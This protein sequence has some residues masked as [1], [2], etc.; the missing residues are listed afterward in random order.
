MTNKEIHNKLMDISIAVASSNDLEAQKAIMELI[1]YFK[2]DY[3][4]E[5]DISK[6]YDPNKE[7][8]DFV[9]GAP[10]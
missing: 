7:W 9:D 10:I 3:E 4:F 8:P 5:K 1:S 6:A 2:S